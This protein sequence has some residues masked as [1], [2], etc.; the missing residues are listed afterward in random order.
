MSPTVPP[1]PAPE[2]LLA[3]ARRLADRHLAGLDPSADRP[4]PA[5]IIVI[6]ETPAPGDLVA[7]AHVVEPVYPHPGEALVGRRLCTTHHGLGLITTGRARVADGAPSSIGLVV[8]ADRAGSFTSVL[9][10]PDHPAGE[11]LPG[12][13]QGWVA[14][15]MRRTLALPTARPE[16]SVGAYF[17]AL[18]LEQLAP[19]VL[20]APGRVRDWRELAQRHPLASAPDDPGVLLG[21]HARIIATTWDWGTVRRRMLGSRHLAGMPCPPWARRVSLHTWFDDGSF[22]RWLQRDLVPVADLLPAVLDALPD[23]LGAELLEGLAEP[24]GRLTTVAPGPA[25]PTT[26]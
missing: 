17:D 21:A 18:W 5:R 7:T 11:V 4:E 14:D 13:P 23:A 6:D 10:G 22:A 20:A 3:L 15:A 9:V 19:V 25:D 1:S 12:A 16:G 2:R 8:L 24:P 26:A